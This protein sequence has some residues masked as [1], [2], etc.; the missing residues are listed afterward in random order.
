VLFEFKTDSVLFRPLKR[1]KPEL[2]LLTFRDLHTLRDRYEPALKKTRR[3]DERLDMREIPSSDLVFRVEEAQEEDRMQSNGSMP[4]RSHVLKPEPRAYTA[5][6]PMRGE[7]LM[8]E[9]G[10]LLVTGIAGTGKSH[11]CGGLVERL[12]AQGVKVDCCAK[13]HTASSR[14]NGCTLDHWVNRH[15]LNGSPTCHLLYLDEVSQIDIGL[16]ALL[17]RL[18]YT[19]MRFLLAGDWNQYAPIAN[20]WRGSP[21]AEEAFERSALLHRM[22]GG[23][24]VNLTECR[25]SDGVLFDFYASLIRGGSRFEIPLCEAVKQ[26]RVQF[27]TDPEPARWNLVI[28][29]AKRV[30][31]NRKLNLHFSRGKEVVRLRVVGAALRGNA[32]Q[33]MLLWVGLQLLGCGGCVKNQVLYTIKEISEEKEELWL[34]GLPKPLSFAQVRGSLRLSFAQT[35]AS[36][37]G[38]QYEEKLRLHDCKTKFFTRK[39]LFVGLSR[40]RSGALVSVAD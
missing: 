9:G 14:I 38:T 16:L 29:H 10:C 11:F 15:V 33:C 7:E 36:V 27:P 32:Q 1:K 28:S 22:C 25:R 8:L 39:M 6:A 17:A 21:I 19:K 26:A 12:R 30:Q 40:S 20:H 2:E 13:T 23:R 31:L 24:F 34:E 18:T 5:L 3:L 35:F 4:H 37:Q